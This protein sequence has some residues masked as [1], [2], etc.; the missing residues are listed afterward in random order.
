MPGNG[1]SVGLLQV[2]IT[3]RLRAID[4]LRARETLLARAEATAHIGSWEWDLETGTTAV[5]DEFCR[6]LGLEIGRPIDHADFAALVHPDDRPRLKGRHALAADGGPA[7]TFDFRIVRPVTGETRHVRLNVSVES[8]P[9][10]RGRYVAV[11]HDVTEEHA[12]QRQIE[13]LDAAMAQATEA[14]VVA[15]R[16][17]RVVYVNPAF[18]RLTGLAAAAVLGRKRHARLS[19]AR[20]MLSRAIAHVART[21]QPWMD[22][23]IDGRPDGS[24]VTSAATVSPISATD[25]TLAGFVTILRDVSRKRAEEQAFERR[26]RERT[27]IAEMLG[28]LRAGAM[29]ED[30]AV[31]VCRRVGEIPEVAMA[32]II[33]FEPDGRATIIG[34]S[35]RASTEQPG[36]RLSPERA[37]YLRER[38]SVG[39]WVERWI[40][41]PS[42]PYQAMIESLGISAHAYAPLRSSG[43]PLGLLIVGTGD[44]D[45]TEVLSE[46]LPALV[47]FAAIT[48]T[49]LAGELE[50]R[51]E[52]ARVELVIRDAIEQRRFTTVFQ[53]IVELAGGAVRGYEALT[54]FDDGRGPDAWFSEA[55][56]LRSALGLDLEAACLKAALS[57]SLDLPQG[58]WLNVNVS[59]ELVM[60]GSL[61]ALL[62]HSPRELVLEI[63]EHAAIRDYTAFRTAV[64][65]LGGRVRLAIDDAGAG[66]SSLRHIVELGPQLVKLDRSL[67]AG[68]DADPAR[69]A[70]VAGMAHFASTAG[71]TLLGEGIET[72]AELATLRALEVELGQGFLIGR[73]SPAASVAV[74]GRAA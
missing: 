4:A 61:D 33:S 12:K 3:D 40:N 53:P 70:I 11:L 14:V 44:P 45:P 34:Q 42:H 1:G 49:L 62:P 18:E 58:A 20:T 8:G 66:Y 32:S 55:H 27:L 10:S 69:Q 50:A 24:S 43:D 65:E 72:E 35:N 47:E 2:D 13:M 31:E 60:A 26:A 19:G 30:T 51:N 25:G 71:L 23:V 5:S 54:R 46:V 67:I 73:P 29:P 41:N 64:A 52:A 22:D 15:D 57:A 7:P 38:A 28:A 9:N 39:P 56:A 74:Q 21:G 48:G 6:I 17:Q 37:A 68:I 59:P 16:D 36:L 63:T